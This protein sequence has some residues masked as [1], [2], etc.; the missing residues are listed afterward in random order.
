MA[1]S[2]RQIS[3][4]RAMIAATVAG[5]MSE[6]VP[7]PKKIERSGRPAVSRPKCTSSRR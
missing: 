6:G 5:S 4:A 2:K 3:E 1:G 7:P